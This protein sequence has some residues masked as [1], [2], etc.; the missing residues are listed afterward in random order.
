MRSI[1]S[2]ETS[3]DWDR[4]R[5]SGLLPLAPSPPLHGADLFAENRCR[6][7]GVVKL[8]AP[9]SSNNHQLHV[10]SCPLHCR[11]RSHDVTGRTS[12]FCW[13]KES[14][15]VMSLLVFETFEERENTM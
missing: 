11:N 14:L 15:K 10:A 5:N 7:G 6:S 1:C 8:E 4:R 3:Y 9:G 12:R 2:P 13:Y